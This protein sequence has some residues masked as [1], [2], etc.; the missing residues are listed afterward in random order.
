MRNIFRTSIEA[1]ILG[2]TSL[3]IFIGFGIFAY[4]SISHEQS[5][6]VA[7]QEDM[8]RSL[9][10]SVHGSL[11]TIML[12]GKS[13][14]TVQI[15]DNL[16]SIS[17]VTQV[18][19]FNTDGGEAFKGGSVAGGLEKEQLTKVLA[20]GGVASFYEGEGDNRLLTE[21]H[22]LPNE[23]ACQSCHTDTLPTRGAVLVSTS[24][25]KM[26][27]TIQS[28]KVFSIAALLLTLA[29]VIISLK[30]L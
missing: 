11:K 25:K 6:M 22:A 13:D 9:A 10:F 12:A 3:L 27:D 2:L 7:R 17:G 19:V 14:L 15:L 24:T 29:L 16:R 1:K 28:S 26:D 5:D 20:S 18:K 21:I 4:L 8:N 23:A 30:V